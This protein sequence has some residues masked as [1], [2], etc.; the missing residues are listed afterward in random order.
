MGLIIA[1]LALITILLSVV[2]GVNSLWLLPLLA[3]ASTSLLGPMWPLGVTVL[4]ST[5]ALGAMNLWDLPLGIALV[6]GAIL[7]GAARNE[8]SFG[9]G[10]AV[11]ISGSRVIAGV[12]NESTLQPGC[13]A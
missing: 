5:G 1:F 6:I 11:G 7:L 4:I 2:L 3:I 9:Y 10:S 8:R 12:P 13:G